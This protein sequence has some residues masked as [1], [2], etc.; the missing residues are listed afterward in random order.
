MFRLAIEP[1]ISQIL[2]VVTEFLTMGQREGRT[3]GFGENQLAG[4][5]IPLVGVSG[6]DVV[7]DRALGKKAELVGTTLFD[8]FCIGE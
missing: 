3:S 4:G 8:K 1:R 5:S 6:A 2:F 7:I